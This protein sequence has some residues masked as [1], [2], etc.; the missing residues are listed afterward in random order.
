MQFIS[1][2]GFL[3][4]ALVPVVS[5]KVQFNKDLRA[6]GC[7]LIS[8]VLL[9]LGGIALFGAYRYGENASVVT[10]ATSLYPFVTVIFAVTFLREKPN[11]FQLIGLFFAATAILLLSL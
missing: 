2:F 11:K 8:G 10:A 9:G 7:A 1:A 4:V 6:N 5:R 3:L